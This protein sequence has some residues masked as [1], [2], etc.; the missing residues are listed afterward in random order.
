M[1]Y[2]TVYQTSSSFSPTKDSSWSQDSHIQISTIWGFLRGTH[3]WVDDPIVT[4]QLEQCWS[5][6]ALVGSKPRPIVQKKK[7]SSRVLKS[8]L[9]KKTSSQNNPN[10]WRPRIQQFY[11]CADLKCFSSAGIPRLGRSNCWRA[12]WSLGRASTNKAWGDIYINVGIVHY[13]H[14]Y[15]L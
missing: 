1:V 12:S 3:P 2:Q 13:I 10:R 15:N 8:I 4:G 6:T 14:V 5:W 11:N 7:A 9:P